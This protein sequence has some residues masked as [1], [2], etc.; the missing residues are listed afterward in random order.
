MRL[1]LIL[2]LIITNG[3]YAQ[4]VQGYRLTVTDG[5]HI[6]AS[7]THSTAD[8]AGYFN[9]HYQPGI[10]RLS[11]IYSWVTSN[12]AYDT[13]SMYVINNHKDP[14]ARIT[15]A[16]R[17]RKGVCEN[18]AAVFNDIAV[19]SG[20]ISNIVNGYTKQAGSIDRNGH[21]WC[22]V[23]LDGNWLFCD[24]T[25][26]EGTREAKKWFLVAPDIF[27]ES[28][29]PF[30]PMWQLLGYRVS[31]KEFYQ[32]VPF[33]Q[34]RKQTVND[35]DSIEAWH[36]LT[37]VEQLESAAE[38]IEQAG[39]YNE[40]IRNNLR[41]T[42]MQAGI[43]REEADMNLYNEA[44]CDFNEANKAVNELVQYRNDHFIPEKPEE[45]LISLLATAASRINASFNKLHLLE[46]SENNY[47]YDPGLLKNRLET[48]SRKMEAQENFVRSYYST[49]VTERDNLFYK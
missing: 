11:A 25:W 28:H 27:I 34:H 1:L 3:L 13:D 41:F 18:F 4:D 32:G 22:V 29:M 37:R 47:Q 48:L 2:A 39:I 23:K 8:I 14:E 30:D 7:Y 5:A 19:K 21:S 44:V 43:I 17:R 35:A 31:H 46:R 24:P 49:K 10:D 26:D 12:I 6:P 38:R 15:E 9:T 42:R 45:E 36:K 40:L 20:F 33:Q 16:L